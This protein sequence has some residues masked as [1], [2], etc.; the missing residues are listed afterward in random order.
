M[1]DNAQ[2]V[3]KI[4]IEISFF[5]FQLNVAVVL[6]RVLGFRPVLSSYTNDF[7]IP[8]Y[9]IVTGKST[10]KSNFF[11]LFAAL[12]FIY[13]YCFKIPFYRVFSIKSTFFFIS[14]FLFYLAFL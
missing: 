13:L 5:L 1:S 4:V 11:K 2:I 14:K 3:N 7:I 8:L 12:V 9:S 6:N 10:P